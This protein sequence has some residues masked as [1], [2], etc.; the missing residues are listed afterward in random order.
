MR[1]RT[2][3]AMFSRRVG[4]YLSIGRAAINGFSGPWM[5]CN[6]AMRARGGEGEIDGIMIGCGGGGHVNFGE[7]GFFGG[8]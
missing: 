5:I 8:R 1:A 7:Y 6:G 4:F 3:I 2:L